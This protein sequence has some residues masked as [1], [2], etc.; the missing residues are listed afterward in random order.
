MRAGRKPAR[1]ASLTFFQVRSRQS[2]V[3]SKIGTSRREQAEQMLRDV[4]Y[5]EPES[6]GV[7]GLVRLEFAYD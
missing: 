1:F 2:K 6:E 5:D 3:Q 7:V 4:L